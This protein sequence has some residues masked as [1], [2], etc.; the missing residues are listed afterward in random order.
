MKKHQV[1]HGTKLV[2][3]LAVVLLAMAGP[4]AAQDLAAGPSAL[5]R[6]SSAGVDFLPEGDYARAV[7][8]VSGGGEVSRYVFGSGD[9]PFVSAFDA[10]GEALADGVYQ[11]ELELVPTVGTRREL[12]IEATKSGGRATSAQEPQSGAFTIVDG[13]IV[14]PTLEEGVSERSAGGLTGLGASSEA[15][16]LAAVGESERSA[17]DSDAVSDMC[18]ARSNLRSAS[19]EVGALSVLANEDAA[20]LDPLAGGYIEPDRVGAGDSD[21]AVAAGGLAASE[22]T[23]T[24][25]SGAITSE[26]ARRFDPEGANGRPRSE[27]DQR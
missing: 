9:T 16:P 5:V 22:L 23:F 17:T 10:E 13:F 1:V 24:E 19:C 3:T 15:E 25:T 27:E 20:A 18:D 26:P 11:W 2:T 6:V 14:D 12:M 7:V 21:S 8:T 4:V